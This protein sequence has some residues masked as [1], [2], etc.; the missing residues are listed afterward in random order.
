MAWGQGYKTLTT[1]FFERVFGT[2]TVFL[3]PG[4]NSQLTITSVYE[5]MNI[6][7]VTNAIPILS[8]VARANI[9]GHEV[10]ATIIG[11]YGTRDNAALRSDLTEQRHTSRCACAYAWPGLR[12][13]WR[14]LHKHWAADCIP[15]AGNGDND[16]RGVPSLL[17][18]WAP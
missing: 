7:H 11:G 15:R 14:G 4:Q 1:S 16:T 9:N 18:R 17:T 5:V 3:F 13:L 8:T 6:P 10:T 2:N 12:R